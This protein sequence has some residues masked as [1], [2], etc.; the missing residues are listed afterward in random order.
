MREH[1]LVYPARAVEVR[2]RAL[3]TERGPDQA[4]VLRL[5]LLILRLRTQPG[6]VRSLPTRVRAGKNERGGGR[7]RGEASVRCVGDGGRGPAEAQ[8]SRR[9]RRGAGEDTADADGARRGRSRRRRRSLRGLLA[10]HVHGPVVVGLDD[11]D[12][13]G[14]GGFVRRLRERRRIRT[15]AGLLLFCRTRRLRRRLRLT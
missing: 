10:S 9:N 13:G 6:G 2:E 4:P 15:V 11:G 5:R 1:R 12:D 8:R 3:V 7:E 14:R